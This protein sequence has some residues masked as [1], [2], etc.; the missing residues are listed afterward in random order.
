MLAPILKY[1]IG[2]NRK[3]V[4]TVGTYDVQHLMNLWAQGKVDLDQIMGQVLQYIKTLQEEVAALDL[5]VRK[6]K[7]RVDE[8]SGDQ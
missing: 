2:I 7:R 6:L 8:L 5:E 3:E 1:R 4:K